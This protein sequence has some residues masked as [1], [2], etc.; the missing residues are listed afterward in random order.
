MREF[1]V[2]VRQFLFKPAPVRP[3]I[4]FE[5]LHEPGSEALA[6]LVDQAVTAQPA[7]VF[8][9]PDQAERPRTWRSEIRQGGKRQREELSGHHLKAP[10]RRTSYTYAQRP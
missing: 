4:P 10:E 5:K 1:C 8:M 9:N 2:V 7:Q 3:G 6:G